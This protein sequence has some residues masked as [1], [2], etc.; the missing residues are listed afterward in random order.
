MHKRLAGSACF[1]LGHFWYRAVLIF[2]C[3]YFTYP[4]YNNLMIKSY[5]LDPDR[6]DLNLHIEGE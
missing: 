5:E 2:D 4:I 6:W 3:M 1:W